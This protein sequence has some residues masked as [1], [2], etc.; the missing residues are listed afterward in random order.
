MIATYKSA[1]SDLRYVPA[2]QLGRYVL[3]IFSGCAVV[4]RLFNQGESP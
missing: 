4:V 2:E 1:R 3:L